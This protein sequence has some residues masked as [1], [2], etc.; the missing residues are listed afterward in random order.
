M[1]RELELRQRREKLQQTVQ[2]GRRVRSG[3]SR[4]ARV[5]QLEG[6]GRSWRM[7]RRMHQRRQG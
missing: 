6:G 4:L 3:C 5:E 7:A 1:W 2:A